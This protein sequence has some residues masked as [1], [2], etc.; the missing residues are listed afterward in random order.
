VGDDAG[1]SGPEITL[2]FLS[3]DGIEAGKTKVR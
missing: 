1:S 2:D 3:A